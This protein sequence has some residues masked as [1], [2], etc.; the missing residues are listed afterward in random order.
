[1]M[2]LGHPQQLFTPLPIAPSQPSRAT[3]PSPHWRLFWG[4]RPRWKNR[5]AGLIGS[6]TRK[7]QALIKR[8]AR[9]ERSKS[10]TMDRR[11]KMS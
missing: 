2:R 1:M 5:R 7:G 4:S 11:T 8:L 6:G 3:P 10:I 9:Q